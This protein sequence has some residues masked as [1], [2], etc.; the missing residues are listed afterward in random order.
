MK[1]A[2]TSSYIATSKSM[3]KSAFTQERNLLKR[4][5]Y[6]NPTNVTTYRKTV[7]AKTY[8]SKPKRKY[9]HKIKRYNKL[10]RQR[11]MKAREKRDKELQKLKEDEE[12]FMNKDSDQSDK[13]ES[14]EDL[15]MDLF[16]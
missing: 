16:G 13:S 1:Q 9:K 3:K 11:K 7:A 5:D 8:P 12:K 2:G 6:P 4:W 10:F 14:E 15:G